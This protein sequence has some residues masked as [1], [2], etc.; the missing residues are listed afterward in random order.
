MS[1]AVVYGGFAAVFVVLSGALIY[2]AGDKLSSPKSSHSSK[3][4]PKSSPHIVNEE[5]I[6]LDSLRSL[7]GRGNKVAASSARGKKKHSKNK[8]RSKKHK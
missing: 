8:T 2:A 7:R 3:S 5:D 4:S 6:G 1:N